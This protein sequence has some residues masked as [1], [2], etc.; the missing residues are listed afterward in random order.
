MSEKRSVLNNLMEVMTALFSAESHS[1]KKSKVAT[2]VSARKSAGRKYKTS[3]SK[4]ANNNYNSSPRNSKRGKE[5]PISPNE[6]YLSF[7][8]ASPFT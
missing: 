1:P 2:H 7:G 4:S 6:S 5:S 3:G 8:S